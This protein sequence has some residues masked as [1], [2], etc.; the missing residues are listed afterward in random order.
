M[1]KLSGFCGI[2]YSAFLKLLVASNSRVRGGAVAAA[3][4][5]MLAR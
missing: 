1:E 5:G 4:S 2:A 3:G